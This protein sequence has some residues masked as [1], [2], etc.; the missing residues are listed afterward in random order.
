MK[1]GFRQSMAWLHTWTGLVVGWVLLLMFMGGTASYYREEIS[2]W[3][4]PELA[5]S[6]VPQ[7]VAAA[8]AVAFLQKTAPTAESW[9]VTLPDARSPA[10]RMFWRNPPPANG[11]PAERGKRYGDAIVDPATGEAVAARDTR[12]GDF[13]YRLHFDLHYVPP[14]WARYIVGFCAMVMLVAIVTGVITHKKI[15]VDFFTFRPGKGQRSWLDFHNA[16][17]VLGLPY[18]LAITYTGIVTL[19]LM[20]LPWGIRAAY[21]EG[22]KAFR[23]EMSA[24]LP[25]VGE[26]SGRPAPSADIAAMIASAREAWNGA[27]VG[28]FTVHHPGD[29][30]ARVDVQAHG[31]GRLAYEGPVI[32][33]DGTTGEIE[34]RTA[35]QPA[36]ALTRNVMYGLHLGRFAPGAMR[37]LLFVC[38]LAGCLM[39]ASG[40][41]LWAVKERPRHLKA[42]RIGF[43]LRLVDSLNI[44]TVAGLPIAFASF[45][46]ANRLLPLDMAARADAEAN[47]FFSAWACA[48]AAAFVAPRR[49]MWCAQLYAGA[50]AFAAIPLL[51]WAT[52]DV[53]LGV[54]LARGDWG[55]AG[56]DLATL[57]LGACLA[58]CAARLRRW[59]PQASASERRRAAHAPGA[60]T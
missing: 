1:Q 39:V 16:T 36:A 23:G 3:T 57:G 21:P 27:R 31:A 43:G 29:A 5:Q 15:F 18:H 51:N 11:A 25:D 40:V 55:L 35:A 33:F 58:A 46:W 13:F 48:L 32:R 7:A 44:G 28:S 49:S 4:R 20:Y 34:A 6:P 8:R 47:V 42:G 30:A 26:A 10:V 19:M 22:E 24:G 2:R 41:I 53:H 54:T 17:A 59:T 60:A 56:V 9:T 38:G 14:R 52:S 50:I 37:M 12:G 45:F